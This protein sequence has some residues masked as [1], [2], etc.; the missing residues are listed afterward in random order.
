MILNKPKFW[1][2]KINF[3]SILLIPFSF[4]FFIISFLK[5]ILT[6]T[7][8]FNIPVI[9]IG[10][11]YVGGTG[12]TPLSIFLAKQLSELGKSPVI[13]K[14]FYKEHFDEHNLIKEQFGNFILCKKRLDGLK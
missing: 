13:I 9:C 5:K 2:K 7:H 6:K 10:N 8:K 3:I 14:K 1:D 4:L 12:K 11:I